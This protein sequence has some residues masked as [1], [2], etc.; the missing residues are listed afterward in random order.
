MSSSSK[1]TLYFNSIVLELVNVV[2]VQ[3]NQH[4]VI[5]VSRLTNQPEFDLILMVI[6][7]IITYIATKGEDFEHFYPFCI[8]HSDYNIFFSFLYLYV[9]VLML[10]GLNSENI[11]QI[12]LKHASLNSSLNIQSNKLNSTH[13]RVAYPS[14]KGNF[15]NK[16]IISTYF[17]RKQYAK[18]CNTLLSY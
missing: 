8:V 4:H 9:L 10:C 6:Q 15:Y 11:V 14:P 2:N 17:I 16:N 7:D 3:F 1:Q 12:N 13:L 5:Q 18:Q